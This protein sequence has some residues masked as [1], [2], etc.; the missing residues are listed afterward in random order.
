MALNAK[1]IERLAGIRAR[2]IDLQQSHPTAFEK[3][4][5]LRLP[6]CVLVESQWLLK[7][8][9]KALKIDPEDLNMEVRT[10]DEDEEFVDEDAELVGSR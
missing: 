6:T 10:P 8:L 9:M 2:L 3:N 7:M 4:E 5:F 1:G